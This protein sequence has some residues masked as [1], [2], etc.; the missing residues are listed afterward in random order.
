MFPFLLLS[1]QHTAGRNHAI[2][3]QCCKGL[4]AL[5]S[6]SEEPMPRQKC[7][8]LM[9]AWD[10]CH[11]D[12]AT[13]FAGNEGLEKAL[14]EFR[15]L[16]FSAVQRGFVEKEEALQRSIA[17]LINECMGKESRAPCWGQLLVQCE[18]YHRLGTAEVFSDE[19][20]ASIASLGN[21]ASLFRHIWAALRLDS[22]TLSDP[23]PFQQQLIL[24]P[25]YVPT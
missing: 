1:E 10:Q 22:L 25:W 9:S 18:D 24:W 3:V 12:L 16:L 14:K 8:E 13:T 19:Q 20:R 21:A 11:S 7:Q 23:F 2:I 4:D 15:A 5:N 17:S 6:E